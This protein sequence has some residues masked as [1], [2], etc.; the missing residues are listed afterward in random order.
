M[1]FMVMLRAFCEICFKQ[2]DTWVQAELCE[3]KDRETRKKRL[4]KGEFEK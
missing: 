3:Q 2:Y 1:I 4:E